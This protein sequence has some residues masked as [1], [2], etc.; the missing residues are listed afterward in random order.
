MISPFILTSNFSTGSASFVDTGLTVSITPSSATSKVYISASASA[1]S[2]AGSGATH[3]Y[4]QYGLIRDS[5]QLQLGTVGHYNFAS[6]N[7]PKEF[8]VYLTVSAM[9]FLY[10]FKSSVLSAIIILIWSFGSLDSKKT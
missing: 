7:N 6:S 2:S 10:S 1:F 4:S 3:N 5:T 8:D 9:P